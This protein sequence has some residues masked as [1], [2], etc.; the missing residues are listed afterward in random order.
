MDPKQVEYWKRKAQK[1]GYIVDAL[2][3]RLRPIYDDVIYIEEGIILD[4]KQELIL[5]TGQKL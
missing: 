4:E 2:I 1:A 3:D 5:S